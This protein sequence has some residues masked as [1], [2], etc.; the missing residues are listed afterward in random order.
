MRGLLGS[1]DRMEQGT[2]T[3]VP[4]GVGTC[5]CE[6]V[7]FEDSDVIVLDTCEEH[8]GVTAVSI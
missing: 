1:D 7:I 8:A 5:Q 4:V 6:L 2:V 3:Q